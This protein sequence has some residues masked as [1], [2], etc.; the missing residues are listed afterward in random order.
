M[1]DPSKSGRTLHQETKFCLGRIPFQNLPSP[2]HQT[3]FGSFQAFKLFLRRFLDCH[4]SLHPQSIKPSKKFWE[5]IWRTPYIMNITPRKEKGY[6]TYSLRLEE[7]N[8]NKEVTFLKQV[9]NP[10]P[11]LRSRHN[12]VFLKVTL[13]SP[14]LWASFYPLSPLSVRST[15]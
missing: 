11:L 1:E 8:I 5:C 7:S 14:C 6:Y 13:S 9:Q 15:K 3:N 2:Q 4:A 12:R 10:L